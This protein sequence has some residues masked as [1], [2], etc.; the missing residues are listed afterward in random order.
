M[1]IK[2]SEKKADKIKNKV[3]EAINRAN[4]YGIPLESIG[5]KAELEASNAIQSINAEIET[6]SN[7]DIFLKITGNN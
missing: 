6:M 5:Y 1:D 7:D 2:V 4:Q 3:L